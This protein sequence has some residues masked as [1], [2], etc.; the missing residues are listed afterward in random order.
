MDKLRPSVR[1]ILRAKE[2]RSRA[3]AALPWPEKVRIV[4]EMQKM[5]FPIVRKR[6]SRACGWRIA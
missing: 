5:G 1:A 6:D 3:L 4:V 2:E